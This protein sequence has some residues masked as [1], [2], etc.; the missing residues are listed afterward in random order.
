MRK[1]W[2]EDDSFW[3]DFHDALFSPRHWEQAPQ[4]IDAVL[5]LSGT[6]PGASVL[7]LCCGP[8]RHSVELA[9]RGFRVTGVDRTGRY[10]DE[11]R[12]K[13]AEMG[14][15]IEFVQSDMREFTRPSAFDLVISL[16]TSFGY[17]EDQDEDR[18]VLRN[19]H[20]S[21]RPEGGPGHGYDGAGGPRTHIQGTGLARGRGTG[22]HH[23]GGP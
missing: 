6:G 12:A 21:L 16:Y 18:K 9:R 17:F 2:H 4:E 7:D 22:H 14:L 3:E 23:A 15:E 20:E 13:A 5:A 11:A 19:I 8:G 10:L 1:P